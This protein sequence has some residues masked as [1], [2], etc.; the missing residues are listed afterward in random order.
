MAMP[1]RGCYHQRV[2]SR[3]IAVDILNVSGPRT[4]RIERAC[5]VRIYLIALGEFWVM[6]IE[7]AGV[8]ELD[9]CLTLSKVGVR[10]YYS[11]KRESAN[12]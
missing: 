8:V 12:A 7:D 9:I 4:R 3:K 2:K 5:R 10:R 6:K 11:E 1:R